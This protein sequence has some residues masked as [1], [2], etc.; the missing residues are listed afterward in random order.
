MPYSRKDA[1]D[2]TK[3]ADAERERAAM[4]ELHARDLS[5]EATPVPAPVIQHCDIVAAQASGALTEAEIVEPEGDGDWAVAATEHVE[6]ERE[7]IGADPDEDDL[8]RYVAPEPVE[9]DPDT[10]TFDESDNTFHSIARDEHE[11][12]TVAELPDENGADLEDA[13]PGF[14]PA[15]GEF[16]TQYPYVDNDGDVPEVGSEPADAPDDTLDGADGR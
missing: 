10:P 14:I 11:G 8:E 3:D 7:R 4:A 2:K 12:R 1:K 16:E 5:N 15:D 9:D 13:D 6:A